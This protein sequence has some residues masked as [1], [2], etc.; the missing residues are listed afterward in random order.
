MT[1]W[2]KGEKM[3]EKKTVLVTGGTRGIGKAVCKRLAADGYQ[4]YLTYLLRHIAQSRPRR[5]GS[6]PEVQYFYPATAPTPPRGRTS[7]RP[8]PRARRPEP[9]SDG[10]DRSRPEQARRSG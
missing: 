8:R 6:R 5:A 9:G 1:D 7:F 4:M 3:S 10:S 2:K